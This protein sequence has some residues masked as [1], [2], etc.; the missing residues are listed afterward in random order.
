MLQN[1]AFVLNAMSWYGAGYWTN[2][3]VLVMFY[4]HFPVVSLL[5]DLSSIWPIQYSKLDSKMKDV[6]F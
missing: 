5:L 3:T 6:V 2:K 1:G 4:M